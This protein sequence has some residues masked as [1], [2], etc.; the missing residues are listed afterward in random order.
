MKG[1]FCERSI[2]SSRV[3]VLQSSHART[4][5]KSTWCLLLLLL[6]LCSSWC[7]FSSSELLS[8]PS[9]RAALAGRC[10]NGTQPT[11]PCC[12]WQRFGSYQSQVARMAGYTVTILPFWLH[13]LNVLSVPVTLAAFWRYLLPS[14][15]HSPTYFNRFIVIKSPSQLWKLH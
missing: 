4:T 11:Q 3:L 15:Y 7:C 9:S 14:E 8:V 6:L 1:L 10:L 13:L 2:E 5:K 12:W